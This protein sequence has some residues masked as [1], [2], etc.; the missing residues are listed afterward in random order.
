MSPI[1]L[2]LLACLCPQG[3][4]KLV[5]PPPP[6]AKPAPA[7]TPRV[8]VQLSEIE[9]FQRQAFQLRRS[10]QLT[11]NAEDLILASIGADYQRPQE[12]ALA[13][14]RKANEDELHG[15]IKIVRR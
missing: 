3:E 12:L 4:P 8:Q 14:A 7:A 5:L 13:L 9:R 11:A 10:A 6:Q 2:C 15:L 1:T